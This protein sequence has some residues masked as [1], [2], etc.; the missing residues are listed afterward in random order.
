MRSVPIRHIAD[1]W[2]SSVDKHTVEGESPIQMCN[3]TDAY[4]KDRV[5]PGPD[6]MRA[7]ATP[8]E[9]ARNRLKVGDSVFTKDSEDPSDI[10]ISAF[11]DGEADD[12]VCGYHLAI[13]RPHAATHPR[14]LNWALRSRPVLEHFGNYAAG[15]SRYGI[16]LSD[17]RSA[18]IPLMENK[19]Q[20]RIASFLDEHVS[21]IDRII[22]ARRNQALLVSAAELE[23]VRSATTLAGSSATR[24]SGIP[25]MPAIGRDAVLW[26]FGQA[27]ETG[28]GTTPKSDRAEYYN[29][30]IPWVTT[31]DL[32]DRRITDLPRSVTDAA[33]RDYS[34]LRVFPPGTVMIAMYGATVG[35]LG[36]LEIPACVN[37]ACCALIER[38]P[39]TLD[40]AF[41]WLLAYRSE[42]MG[43]ASGSGQPN[44]S[45]EIVRGLQIPVPN[46]KKQK[47][48]VA[49][50]EDYT[51]S[52]QRLNE[53][54][55]RSITL[56]GEYQSSLITAAVSGELDVTT[57]GST[58][59]R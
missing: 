46:R 32:R 11:V 15:I 23:H 35:R 39:V 38:G 10:G 30:H 12:F 22:A 40:Y 34:A 3:Y 47:E 18:P 58:I 20:R 41:F 13:A 17:L 49:E 4:K 6:L 53:A 28:S 52:T 44:I 26:R 36:R 9:I 16:G 57:A 24:A 37:Q 27:F 51:V 42:I 59:P 56:L 31:S 54:L 5:R 29:G 1:V 33:M 2:T 50:L 14:F 48:I 55:A 43:L 45:Q 21:R 19:D 8:T 25:W 7:T